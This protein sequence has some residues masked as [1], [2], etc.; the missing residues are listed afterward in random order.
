MILSMRLKKKDKIK[1]LLE[2]LRQ[3]T[4]C[5]FQ[6]QN[7]KQKKNQNVALGGKDRLLENYRPLQLKIHDY[8]CAH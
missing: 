8:Y 1:E 2:E 7:V 3:M 6:V 4:A 5:G